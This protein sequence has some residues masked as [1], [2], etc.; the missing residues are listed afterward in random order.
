[1]SGFNY[2]LLY[3]KIET[4]SINDIFPDHYS[5]A[6][7]INS[8]L[9]NTRSDDINLISGE[10]YTFGYDISNYNKIVAA[11]NIARTI[12][13]CFLLITTTIFFSSDLEFTAIA[14]LEDMMETV[15]KIAINPLNAIR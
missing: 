14:P 10:G 7:D 12:F 3:F 13:V 11:F 5:Y 2:P 9:Q 1:M 15:R 6:G 4:G 8:I